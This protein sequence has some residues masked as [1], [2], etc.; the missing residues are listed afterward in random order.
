M[1]GIV[2][3]L[4]VGGTPEIVER[5]YASCKLHRP[6]ADEFRRRAGRRRGGFPGAVRFA[7]CEP[8]RSPARGRAGRGEGG[9]GGGAARLQALRDRAA[10]AAADA[11]EDP[12]HRHQLRQPQRRFQRSRR[13][14]ISQHVLPPSRLLRRRRAAAGASESV[15]A[16]RL[17]GRDR[18]GDRPRGPSRAQGPR[19]RLH[20]G[21]H[22]V[23]R[24]HACA[25]G[26]ATASST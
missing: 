12:L 16:A 17:R 8:R 10:A 11:R 23:Q 21:L 22:A 20:P 26:C 25:T 24:G 14:E 13:A 6:R 19:P 2:P 5:R 18:H 1:S 3:P 9:A 4:R 7:V 15:R